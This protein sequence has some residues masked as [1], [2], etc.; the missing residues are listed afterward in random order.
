MLKE[1]VVK[2]S[3]EMRMQWGRRVVKSDGTSETGAASRCAGYAV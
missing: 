1:G 2:G 3:N